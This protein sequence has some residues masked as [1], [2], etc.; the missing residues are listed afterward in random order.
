MDG[1]TS[2]GWTYFK[3]GPISLWEGNAQCASPFPWMTSSV[4]VKDVLASFCSARGLKVNAAAGDD[5]ESGCQ[6]SA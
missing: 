5:G 6:Y 4:V 3:G 2:W 1:F